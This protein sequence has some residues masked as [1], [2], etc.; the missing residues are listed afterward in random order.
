MGKRGPLAMGNEVELRSSVPREVDDAVNVLVRV[1]G[2]S[3][4]HLVRV[5][6]TDLL[7]QAGVL[8]PEV[9]ATL[10]PTAPAG[11]SRNEQENKS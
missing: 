8:F 9:S 2:I 3:R 10:R 5:A 11:R 4:A 1:G 7:T 6:I